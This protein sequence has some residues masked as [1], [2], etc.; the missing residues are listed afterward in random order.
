MQDARS[1][2]VRAPSTYKGLELID[3]RAGIWIQIFDQRVV[4]RVHM[5]VDVDDSEA[6]P[7][8]GC[9]LPFLPDM[10]A[11]QPFDTLRDRPRRPF[12]TV[13]EPAPCSRSRK[14]GCR[15]RQPTK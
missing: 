12:R 13:V 9:P 1:G 10:A 3:A 7:H 8:R 2:P 15:R 14:S 6:V 11:G 5:G 4:A